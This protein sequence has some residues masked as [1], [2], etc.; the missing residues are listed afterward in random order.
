MSS[1][2]KVMWCAPSTSCTG[3]VLLT[4]WVLARH[5]ATG[6]AA[7]LPITERCYRRYPRR[8]L[9]TAMKEVLLW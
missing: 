8:S 7:A 6:A 5:A 1:V 4:D 9:W 2:R 3:G